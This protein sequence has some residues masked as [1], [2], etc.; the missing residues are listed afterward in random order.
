MV[1]GYSQSSLYKDSY[2]FFFQIHVLTGTSV[3]N[4]NYLMPIKSPIIKIW[5]PLLLR[6]IGVQPYRLSAVL[7]LRF[8]D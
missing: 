4:W 8:I 1:K 2:I 3:K 6:S 7:L 5:Q